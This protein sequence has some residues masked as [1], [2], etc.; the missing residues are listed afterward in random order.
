[1][2]ENRLYV[3]R[4]NT[5]NELLKLE[6]GEGPNSHLK[7]VN[8]FGSKIARVSYLKEISVGPDSVGGE[9]EQELARGEQPIVVVDNL[10]KASRAFN[11]L[12]QVIPENDR[13]VIGVS[14]PPGSGKS[15]FSALLASYFAEAGHSS[16]IVSV[17]N[18]YHLTTHE[19]AARRS[20]LFREGG[21]ALKEYLGSQD[22]VDLERIEGIVSDFKAGAESVCL[23]KLD[24]VQGVV[25]EEQ[26][27]VSCEGIQVLI[28]E[29]TWSLLLDSLD[30]YTY[31]M[32]RPDLTLQRRIKRGREAIT[33]ELERIIAYEQQKLEQLHPSADLVI[34]DDYFLELPSGK[35]QEL[36]PG[37]EGIEHLKE[38]VM[39]ARRDSTTLPD[40]TLGELREADGQYCALPPASLDESFERAKE[41]LKQVTFPAGIV[42]S[43]ADVTNYRRVWARDA[44]ITGVGGLVAREEV[45]VQGLRSSLE[46]LAS[47]IGPEGQVPSNVSFADDGTVEAVSYGG[48]AGRVDTIPWFVIGACNLGRILDDEEFL[49]QH[50][51]A[52][53]R[54]LELMKAWEFN[55]RGLVYMPQGGDWADEYIY[56]GYVLLPQLLRL[57]AL[58]LYGETYSDFEKLEQAKLLRRLIE[59]N[60]WPLEE[61]RGAEE[62]YHPHAFERYL[63]Q[64]SSAEY[65]EASM[66]PTGYA[67]QFDFFGNALIVLLQLGSNQQRSTLI[68]YGQNIVQTSQLGICPSFWP[69]IFEEDPEWY[70]LSSN[71]RDKFS[72]TTFHYHNGGSWPMV[73][74][75]WG[76]ALCKE[77]RVDDAT[78]LL[79]HMQVAN[80]K[81]RGDSSW[82][83]NEVFSSLS[84]EPHG[85]APCAWSA[86]APLFLNALIKG[87]G[88]LY[89]ANPA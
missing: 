70:H 79:N 86:S 5:P 57:W 23:R 82:E 1:M 64:R 11:L 81:G 65:F 72:N 34:Y 6:T 28:V 47:C 42:A 14:G 49:K 10:I 36:L 8:S 12:D 54:G 85:V 55:S 73:T 66:S 9:V 41:V 15:Q 35:L 37:D 19:N 30:I 50:Q 67:R 78:E 18:Y 43:T 44:V 40:S 69:P 62:V 71:Y 59:V 75:W 29:G 16:Y 22:E 87:V 33:Q 27:S 7:V 4:T 3:V 21:S 68:D 51:S 77:S 45:A 61:N 46:T 31:V 2:T 26:Q 83:F 13:I 60:Y 38:R 74:G 48:L 84:G 56:Q 25:I 58:Q 20:A 53:S 63:Q 89:M 24:L 17:D 88:D 52:M 76:A 39:G 80:A 32:S